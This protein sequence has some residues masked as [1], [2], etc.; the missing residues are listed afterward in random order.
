V[1][2]SPDIFAVISGNI[3]LERVA[4]DPGTYAVSTV[5]FTSYSKISKIVKIKDVP[6]ALF[7]NGMIYLA[8]P[9]NYLLLADSILGLIF[10]LK[11]TTLEI[12]VVIEI[13]K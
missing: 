5:D 2:I 10:R 8:C 1:E 9:T 11:L 3:S 4:P 7:I 12:D 13:S 6:Q